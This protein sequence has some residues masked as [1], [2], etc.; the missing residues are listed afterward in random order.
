MVSINVPSVEMSD[1]PDRPLLGIDIDQVELLRQVGYSW[2]EVADAMGVSR[3]TLWRRLQEQ[4]VTLSS[5][6]DISD[7]DLDSLIRSEFPLEF[8]TC[9]GSG[10]SPEHRGSSSKS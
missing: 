1:R 7:A 9:Y 4:N 10:S 8:W 3:T 5:Y 6:S 2:Q